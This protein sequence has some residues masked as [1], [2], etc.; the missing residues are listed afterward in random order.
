MKKKIIYIFGGLYTPNGM[1][2]MISQKVNYL[3]DNTDYEMGLVLTERPNAPRYYQLSKNVK[4][5]NFNINFDELDTMPFFKKL[6]FYG[7]KQHRYKK[8]LTSYLLSERADIVVSVTR[9]EINFLTKIKDGSKKIAEIHFARTFYRQINKRYFPS[10]VNQ[11]LS[12]L[13]MN[14]LIRNLK[15]LERFVVLTNE[16]KN[17]WPELNNVIVIPNFVSYV[18]NEKSNLSAKRVIAVGRYSQQKGFDMLIHAWKIVN[19][20]Y[21]EWQLHIFGPGDKDVYQKMADQDGLNQVVFC[22]HATDDIYT[23]YT[24]SSIFVLSSRYE[25]FGLVIVEAMGA[26]LPIV[27][28]SCPCGPKDIITEGVDGFLVE[29]CNINSMAERLC[30]LMGNASLRKRMAENSVK[31]VALYSQEVIMNSWIKL[32]EEL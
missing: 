7:L 31:K 15:H 6:L 23:E 21:P 19:Q 3:A 10:C 30:L 4:S 16:D 25:G 27:S 9:R 8:Q 2:Y 32:F 28:F 24:K 11:L 14:S 1:G 5:V 18:P 13:W 29:P 26:G 12:S 22:H 17:N 20:F